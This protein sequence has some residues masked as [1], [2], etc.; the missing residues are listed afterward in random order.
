ML[1]NSYAFLFGF[2]PVALVGFWIVGQRRPDWALLWLTAISLFFYGWWRPINIL[3]IAPSILINFG[4]SR[5]LQHTSGPRPAL[6]RVLLVAGIVFNLCF[7]GYFKYLT[8]LQSAA[9]DVFGANFALTHLILPLGISFITFQKIAFLVDVHAGRVTKFS[10][11]DYS[12]FVLFF[13][14]LIAGPIV[15]YREMMPQFHVMTRRFD[16][17]NAA[18]GVSLFFLGLAKKLV[19]A[20]PLSH[21]VAP[22]YA[23]AGAGVPLSLTDAWIAA[24]GFT[25]QIYFDFSG[26]S[27]MALGLARVFGIKLPVNFNSPLKASSIIDFWLRW[28]VSLTR[29]LTAYIYNPLTLHLARRRMARGKSA[30]GGRNTTASAFV[31]MLMMPTIL[32]ML[33]SG[34]WHGAGYTYI[35]WGLMHGILLSINHAWR[36]LRPRF[37]KDTKSY[38]RAMKPI[39]FVLTFASVVFAMAMFRAPTAASAVA[40]WKGMVGVYGASLPAVVFA[41]LGTSASWLSAIGFTPAWSSGSLLV[42]ATLRIGALL[43]IALLLPNSLEML[44]AFEP[45]IGMKP[46]KQPGWLLRQLTWS[47]ASFPAVGLAVIAAAG[48]LSLGELSEF[49]YWQF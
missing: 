32:T 7:L 33:I 2:L 34:W 21:V 22:L 27:D 26:Y 42:E 45:A 44:A 49:L 9:N 4:L 41:R 16:P 47:P 6:A 5:A 36:V 18:V 12:L 25:L 3:L 20:D 14:Q 1:F 15:H 23:Q 10:F 37:W 43:A 8:F 19:L 11:R 24:L 39:G 30:F 48:I 40:V 28:H 29:F 13:P 31:T 46:V 17:A 38:A 35:L